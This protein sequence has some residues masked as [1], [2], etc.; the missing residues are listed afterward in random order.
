MNEDRDRTLI[1]AMADAID[2]G[3]LRDA[4]EERRIEDRTI[5][6]KI[7]AKDALDAALAVCGED[8]EPL[9]TWRDEW[10]Q[11]AW[12]DPTD[13]GDVA[14]LEYSDDGRPVAFASMIYDDD[15]L[16]A[17]PWQPVFR[18]REEP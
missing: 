9:L 15:R 1:E 4:Y 11:V 5:A 12:V 16:V 8:G 3:D 7:I 10:E 14:P 18:R 17:V 13:L 2:T 6:R